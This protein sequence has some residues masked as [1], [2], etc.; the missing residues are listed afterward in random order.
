MHRVAPMLT[1]LTAAVF[2][3]FLEPV[4][5]VEADR[6]CLRGRN[7]GF[8]GNCQFATRSQCLASASGTNAYCGIN[9]RYAAPRRR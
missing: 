3:A 2:L 9:P 6:Y 7:W 5:A 4:R 1:L 8:P